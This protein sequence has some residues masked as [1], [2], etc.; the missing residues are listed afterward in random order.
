MVGTE[1]GQYFVNYQFCCK[2]IK[3]GGDATTAQIF[4]AN[5][6]VGWLDSI[7][8]S[9]SFHQSCVGT[10]KINGVGILEIPQ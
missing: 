7:N 3:S 8:F 2:T 1:R 6:V 5:D 4:M 10:Y 9:V